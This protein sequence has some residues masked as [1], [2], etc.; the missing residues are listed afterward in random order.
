[1]TKIKSTLSNTYSITVSGVEGLSD[2]PAFFPKSLI[3]RLMQM[4]IS[5]GMNSIMSAPASAYW[6]GIA[7]DQSLNAHQMLVR[8]RARAPITGVQR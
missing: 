2:T 4:R 8:H 6:R 1:M 3:K 7:R 5:F